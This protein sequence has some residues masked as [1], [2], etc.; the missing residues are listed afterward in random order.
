MPEEERLAVLHGPDKGK[1]WRLDTAERYAIG[2][3]RENAIVLTDE[4]VS[5]HHAVLQFED[6]I[7]FVDDVGSKHG[8]WVNDARVEAR[9]PLFHKDVIRV[10]RSHLVYLHGKPD[11]GKEGQ[12]PAG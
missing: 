4:T 12:G 10:G 3:V 6:G 11:E 2:R 1:V 7:W 8:T 9:K 5:Q